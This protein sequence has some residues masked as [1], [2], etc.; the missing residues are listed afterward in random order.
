MRQEYEEFL[1]KKF[2]L[3]YADYS[4]SATKTGMGRLS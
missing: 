1:V 2:P 3:L 4:K